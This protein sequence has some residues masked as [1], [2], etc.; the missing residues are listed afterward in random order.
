MG[1]VI[2]P[3]GDIMNNC[4]DLVS[5]SAFV[6]VASFAYPCAHEV[7]AGSCQTGGGPRYWNNRFHRVHNGW[8][9]E[10]PW[11]DC[12]P[13]ARCL[14]F[15]RLI[16]EA[17]INAEIVCNADGSGYYGW[18]L[19]GSADEQ[20]KAMLVYDSYK[21]IYERCYAGLAACCLSP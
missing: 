14:T 4:A 20:A 19:P 21:R 11:G 17:D 8:S 13:Q 18:A 16:R 10:A 15:D 12:S 7:G 5:A 9:P 3:F 1:R 6:S 2:K